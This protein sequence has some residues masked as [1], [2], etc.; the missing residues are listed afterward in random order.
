MQKWYSSDIC[1]QNNLLPTTLFKDIFSSRAWIC[2]ATPFTAG[3]VLQNS[4]PGQYWGRVARQSLWISQLSGQRL[5][6]TGYSIL[7]KGCHNAFCS[8]LLEIYYLPQCFCLNSILILN[9]EERNVVSGRQCVTVRKNTW[10]VMAIITTTINCCVFGRE[11]Y[12]FI[13]IGN[14][15]I[16]LFLRFRSFQ[17]KNNLQNLNWTRLLKYSVILGNCTAIFL[18]QPSFWHLA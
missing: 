8:F 12:H 10:F 11:V 9:T 1:S 3:A 14:I 2:F 4:S 16:Q 6:L 7:Q 15:T 5:C 13:F 18:F 17:S